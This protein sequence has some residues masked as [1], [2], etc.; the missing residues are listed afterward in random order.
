M[1]TDHMIRHCVMLRLAHDVDPAGLDRVMVG[2]ADLVARLEGCDGFIAGPNRDFEGK[3][4]D[5]PYGFTLDAVDA[6]ALAGY[7]RHPEHLALGSQLVQMC[8]GDGSGVVVYD[9]EVSP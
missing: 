9:L 6:G 8:Q 5:F 7:A 2:L 4:P 1:D 3:S